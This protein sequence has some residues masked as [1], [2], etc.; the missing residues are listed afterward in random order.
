[1]FKQL[2][3]SYGYLEPSVE[4]YKK[5]LILDLD[6]TLIHTFFEPRSDADIVLKINIEGNLY[7]I[8]VLLRPGALKFISWMSKIYEVVV[9]TASMH[10]Y[11]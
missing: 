9:F 2:N 4:S 8:F 7:K 3:G 11:A 1:M 10:S 6:E 5:T